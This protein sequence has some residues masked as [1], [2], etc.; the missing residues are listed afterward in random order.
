M[1][2]PVI[3]LEID[4]RGYPAPGQLVD[5]DGDPG[6]TPYPRS[7]RKSRTALTRRLASGSSARDSL[8]K[9]ARID[10]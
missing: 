9:M 5:L 8:A 10:H 7:E 4:K 2:Y 6:K 3:A 1:I